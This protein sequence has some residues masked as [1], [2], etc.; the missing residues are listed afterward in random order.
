MKG[1]LIEKQKVS[2]GYIYDMV[3]SNDGKKLLFCTSANSI[4][5]RSYPD[6]ENELYKTDLRNLYTT[7]LCFH[8]SENI[9]GCGSSEGDVYLFDASNGTEIAKL[10][11]TVEDLNSEEKFI[12]SVSFSPDGQFVIATKT[13]KVI[14]WETKSKRRIKEFRGYTTSIPQVMFHADNKSIVC[15]QADNYLTAWNLTTGKPLWKQ[16]PFPNGVLAVAVSP[17]NKKLVCGSGLTFSFDNNYNSSALK[18]YSANKGKLI[19]TIADAAV[20]ASELLY[21]SDGRYLASTSFDGFSLWDT[22]TLKNITPIDSI[23]DS[24]IVFDKSNKKICVAGRDITEIDIESKKILR[25]IDGISI[26]IKSICYSNDERLI[27]TS[28]RQGNI[29]FFN[30]NT[31]KAICNLVVLQNSNDYVFYTPDG[32]YMSTREGTRAVHF[33]QDKAVFLFDQFDL[34][35]NRPDI[36]MERLGFASDELIQ[37]Y[38]KAYEKRL[39]KSG[40]KE[41]DFTTDKH[42]PVIEILNRE[43]IPYLTKKAGLTLEVSAIDDKYELAKINVWIN[44]VPVFG[45]GGINL[46]N[47]KLKKTIQNIDLLLSQGENKIEISVHNSK[48]VESYRKTVFVKLDQKPRKPDLYM[49]AIGVS[50]YKEKSFNLQ[51]A[52]KDAMDVA[53][54][55]ASNNEL[56]NKVHQM[57]L[58]NEN[59]VKEKIVVIKN[60][61]QKS[62]VDDMVI[63]FVASHGLLDENLDYFIATHDIDFL[64]PALRG[65][66]YEAL[67]NLLDSI[68]ARK[69]L[70]MIDA[71]HSGEVDKDEGLLLA[72]Q[73]T[74]ENVRFRGNASLRGFKPISKIGF[75]NSFELMKELFTDLRRGT[76]AIVISSAGGGEFAYE[77]ESWKNGVFTYSLIEGLQTGKADNNNNGEISVS[78]IR[79]YVFDKVSKFTQGRQNPTSRRENLEFDFRVW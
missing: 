52:A 60:D 4:S 64:N 45:S 6:I 59:V 25:T 37:T 63:I 73:S 31:Y 75:R 20:F 32:Y 65:L 78:E 35:F 74:V 62:H 54:T 55:F 8:P 67:E 70:M 9:F 44:N 56:F 40:F 71:C 26:D 50:E 43:K 76:G 57:V 66:K 61:L 18:F 38:Q 23:Y 79:N 17:D 19:D 34:Q 46:R 10:E 13:N 41:E 2:F 69:K 72:N 48:G 1:K 42:I 33:I 27:M 22:K 7:D 39:Q 51:Y 53:K 21:S 30:N 3:F 47:Q 11:M 49:V 28:S 29:T 24:E 5:A 14:L 12:S 58:L 15:C 16:Q 68:P 36:I 77:G